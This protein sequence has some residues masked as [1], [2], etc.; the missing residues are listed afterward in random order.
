PLFYQ[1]TSLRRRQ[2]CDVRERRLDAEDLSFARQMG[3]RRMTTPEKAP[4]PCDDA[5]DMRWLV[6]LCAVVGTASVLVVGQQPTTGTQSRPVF[7]TGVEMVRIDV[8]VTDQDGH[9]VHG[10]RREDFTV[11]DRKR[12]R[13]IVNFEEIS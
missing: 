3:N 11:L 6:L 1:G 8:V 4:S 9:A 2:N 10:L 12:P 5:V 13:T 7:R